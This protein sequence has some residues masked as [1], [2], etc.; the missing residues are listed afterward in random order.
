MVPV[1]VPHARSIS[2]VSITGI[3]MVNVS[4]VHLLYALVSEGISKHS[5]RL[6][7]E[8]DKHIII[9]LRALLAKP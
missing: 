5:S 6:H 4:A 2:T 1:A 9:S 7:G 3:T 8:I